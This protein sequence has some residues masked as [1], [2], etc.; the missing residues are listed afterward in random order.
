[1]AINNIYLNNKDVEMI[2]ESLTD[3]AKYYDGVGD[4]KE[5]QHRRDLIKKILS[6]QALEEQ[7]R[8]DRKAKKL[9]GS[10]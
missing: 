4:S 3:S 6:R 5:A 10:K 7:Q 9:G 1:M 2:T 8:K